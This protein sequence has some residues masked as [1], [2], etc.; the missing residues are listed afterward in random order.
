MIKRIFYS[1][2]VLL[3]LTVAA[4]SQN[5]KPLS[6]DREIK[7]IKLGTKRGNE[8][9]KAGLS[10]GYPVGFTA[11]YSF[12][13]YFELNG[14][15]GSDYDDL[16]LGVSGLF[17]VVNIDIAGEKFPLSIGPAF[18]NYFGE[19]YKLDALVFARL[20]YSFEKIPLNLFVEAGAGIRLRKFADKAGSCALGVRYIF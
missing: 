15:I 7:T 5:A 16:T 9:L 17:T 14:L 20:E 3:M 19:K 18:Y 2:L 12:S 8:K 1:I 6:E 10:L 11:G 13:N 4:N